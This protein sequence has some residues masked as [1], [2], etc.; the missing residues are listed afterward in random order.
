MVMSNCMM[1]EGGQT[2]TPLTER[3][4]ESYVPDNIVKND[5]D[6]IAIFVKSKLEEQRNKYKMHHVSN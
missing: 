3:T 1:I 4:R 2:S 6:Q 5:N